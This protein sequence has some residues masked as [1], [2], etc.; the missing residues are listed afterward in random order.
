METS[1][2]L[3]LAQ[4]LTLSASISRVLPGLGAKRKAEAEL[5]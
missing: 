5:I 4:Q 3:S 1:L 2:T